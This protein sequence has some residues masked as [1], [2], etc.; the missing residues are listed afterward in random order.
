[1]EWY[2]LLAWV[3]VGLAAFNAGLFL[4]KWAIKRASQGKEPAIR[5]AW[6]QK[7]Q[8]FSKIHRLTGLLLI[9]FG[10]L[11]GYLALGNR[12][13]WHT[14][15]LLWISILVIFAI[16]L[17]GK[18]KIIKAWVQWHRIADLCFWGLLLLHLLNPWLF[19]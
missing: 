2:V 9:V 10:L 8:L 19:L 15:M 16:F 1:M 12:I 4:I 13:A 5:K 14:G 18:A 7:I 3:N 6:M 17:L 11:H